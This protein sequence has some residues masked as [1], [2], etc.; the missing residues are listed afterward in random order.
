MPNQLHIICLDVPLPADYGGAIDMFYRIQALHDLG[1]ELTL[2]VFHY[3]RAKQSELEKYGKVIYYERKR[4]FWHLF[5]KRPF[6][7]QSRMSAELLANL[8]KDDSP[9][10]FEGIHTTWPLEMIDI[11]QRLTIVRMHNLED[12]Y[13]QGLRNHA[14]GYKKLYF[15]Q[16]RLKLKRYTTYLKWASHI[17]AIKPTDAEM[18]KSIHSSVHVLPVSIPSLNTSYTSTK[19]FALFHGNLSVPENEQAASW[20]I[21]QVKGVSSEAFPVRIAGKNPSKRLQQLCKTL[22]ID[23]IANPSKLELDE[24]VNRAQI[25]LLYTDVSAGIKLKLINCLAGSGQVLV[26]EKMVKG[27]GLEALCIVATDADSFKR[28]FISLQHVPLTQQE[29]EERQNVLENHF[30]THQNCKLIQELIN[31]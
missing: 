23:L 19:P 4:S 17:L 14:R 28:H 3:G 27:T 18:L 26:N 9:I 16:E 25:H 7:V 1:M 11:Q 12:E 8:R 15:E 2:H 6:I 10:L 13:Y 5:S 31:S 30:S 20:I 21:R 22:N 29:F 24:L